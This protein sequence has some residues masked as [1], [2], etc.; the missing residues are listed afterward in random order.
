MAVVFATQFDCMLRGLRQSHSR[1][2][3]LGKNAFV[4]DFIMLRLAA[5]FFG[6]DFL[7]F[8]LG[9]HRCRVCRSRHRMRGLATTGNARPWQI[10]CRV[11]PGQ[12]AFFPR[13]TKHLS[14][15]AMT[16]NNR[17]R[18]QVPDSRWDRNPPIGLDH[19]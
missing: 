1:S 2:A 3:A 10:L 15:D 4:G 13:H 18:A 16:V 5:E 12:V 19:E 9:I 11:A 8:L 14:N 7:Q 17:F 6:R